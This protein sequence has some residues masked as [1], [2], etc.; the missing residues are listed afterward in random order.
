MIELVTTID[1]TILFVND[2]T[3]CY[4]LLYKSYPKYICSVFY[5]ELI[6]VIEEIKI[7]W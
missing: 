1:E 7:M 3:P 6:L 4:I 5:E 2:Q